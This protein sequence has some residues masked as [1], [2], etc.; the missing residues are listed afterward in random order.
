MPQTRFVLKKA[1]ALKKKVTVVV[2]KID[3]PSARP[4]WVL[5]ATFE[6]FMD[7]GA[8][9]EQCDFPVVYASGVNGIAGMSPDEMA[10]DLQ[11]MFDMI[12]K[13]VSRGAVTLRTL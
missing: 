12:I 6:L 13:E 8:T 5:D 4:D 10:P 11:P 2:N 7:L 9:D 3:R 1:L